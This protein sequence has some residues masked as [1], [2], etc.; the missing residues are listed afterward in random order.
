VFYEQHDPSKTAAQMR[1][2]LD[3]QG[4]TALQLQGL[5]T[6]LERRYGEHPITVFQ[7]VTNPPAVRATPPSID[8]QRSLSHSADTGGAGE[9][10]GIDHTK[11]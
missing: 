5:F 10:H 4:S 8:H 7:R 2:L 11:H 1:R 6:K 3:K 9:D